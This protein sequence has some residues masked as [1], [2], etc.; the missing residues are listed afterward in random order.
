MPGPLRREFRQIA[1][2][3]TSGA[4]ELA[5][6]AVT[7]LEDWL[8]R[9]PNPSEAEVEE[10]V[11]HLLHLQPSMAP[12]LRLANEV[13]LAADSGRPG[14]SLARAARDFRKCLEGAPRRI[15]KLFAG[16]LDGHARWPIAIFS[17]SSTVVAAV[18]RARRRISSVLTSECRPGMEGLVS[19]SKLSRAGVQVRLTTDAGLL[20]LLQGVRVVLVGADAMLSHAFVNKIGTRALYLR[21]REAGCQFWVLTDSTKLLPEGIAAPFW[22]PSDGP[23]GEVWPRPTRGVQV[24][25]PLFE[26]TELGDEVRV[27]TE[28]GWLDS[29]QVREAVEGIQISPRLKRLAD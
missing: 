27:L 26:H 2:D 1:R 16:E 29:A 6:R 18:A 24:L 5:L 15:A 25:N 9:H 4:A 22:R 8:R 14:A 20:S 23:P 19:V 21:A 12:L 7:E 13:A 28:A 11:V 17:Y 10:L 3:R